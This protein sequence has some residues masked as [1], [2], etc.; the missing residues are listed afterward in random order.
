[1]LHNIQRA[2]VYS[3][4][5]L[6]YCRKST[7]CGTQANFTS[8]FPCSVIIEPIYASLLNAFNAVKR[9]VKEMAQQ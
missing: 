2:L 3:V 6:L 5:I 7:V 9:F 1:M 8:Y 4:L